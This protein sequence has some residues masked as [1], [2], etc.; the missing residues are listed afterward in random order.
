MLLPAQGGGDQELILGCPNVDAIYSL[1]RTLY[2][3]QS[4]LLTET[5]S[6]KKKKIKKAG[7][8]GGK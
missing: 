2:A 5:D 4:K 7:R 6:K 3:P 8:K 1:Q